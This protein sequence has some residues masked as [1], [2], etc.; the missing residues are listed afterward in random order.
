MNG[1]KC[2]C[3]FCD[4]CNNCVEEK[5]IFDDECFGKDEDEED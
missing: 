5:E 2:M 3:W 1:F 4:C